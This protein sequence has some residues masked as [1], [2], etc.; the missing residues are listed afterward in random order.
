MTEL[1]KLLEQKKEIER[2]IKALTCPK[3]I[4]D[5]ASLE[6]ASRRG[7]PLDCW[8]VRLQE[9]G[10]TTQYKEIVLARTKEEAIEGIF[11]LIYTLNLLVDSIDGAHEVA[12]K[13]RR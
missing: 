4:V 2:Q 3:Y 1:E 9:I 8:R 10:A 13:M 11:N 6:R 12:E 7:E 5:G